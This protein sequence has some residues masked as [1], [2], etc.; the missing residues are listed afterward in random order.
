M[1]ASLRELCRADNYL[2]AG[3][4]ACSVSSMKWP[5]SALAGTP[6][7]T[8][9]ERFAWGGLNNILAAGF[10]KH[11]QNCVRDASGGPGHRTVPETVGTIP[12]YGGVT[13]EKR[14]PEAWMWEE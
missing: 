1:K 13:N 14:R 12:K 3:G 9:H 11:G 5:L 8:L 10:S 6:S 4:K 7:R 2:L